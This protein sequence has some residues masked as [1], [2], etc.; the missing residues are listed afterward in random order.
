MII[1]DKKIDFFFIKFPI[2]FPLVY[3]AALFGMPDYGYVIAFC[4]LLFLAEPHFGATWTVFFDEKMRAY[5]KNHTFLF[6]QAPILI[7]IGSTILFFKFT[8]I[9]YILFFAF[10]IYH[11]TRQS[12]GICKLFSASS[13][14]KLLQ[15]YSLYF[16]NFLSFVGIL[17]FHMFNLISEKQ[18]FLFGFL[19][20]GCSLILIIIQ[21]IK[22]TNWETALTTL[23]GFLMFIPAFF[24]NEPIHAM[25]AGITM[26][27]SQYL[28]MTLKITMGKSNSNYHA[29]S[30]KASV[31]NF[32][33][34]LFLIIGYGTIATLVT[35]FS[36]SGTGA[37][38]KLIL[39]PLLGQIL[40]FYIDG[41]V[42]KFSK[43][44]VREINL[45]FLFNKN[46]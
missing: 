9:F 27:Y 41:L 30:A 39:L 31:F 46:F 19:L 38:A 21:K 32:K 25:L 14:E 2:F 8:V 35:S 28:A 29:I 44:E 15:E 24:V 34:Y 17:S 43:K 42:W 20:I 10:N 22:F 18:A 23:T 12:I 45:K 5:A 16:M 26:H 3:L 33:H 1:F 40:H 11:V 36:A 7:I 4:T 37:F 6:I 13:D